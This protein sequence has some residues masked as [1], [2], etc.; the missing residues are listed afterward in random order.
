M[1]LFYFYHKG[2]YKYTDM[3]FGMIIAALVVMMDLTP[4]MKL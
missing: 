2:D 4:K 1:G 3:K